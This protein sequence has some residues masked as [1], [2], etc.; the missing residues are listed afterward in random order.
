MKYDVD[1]ELYD[2]RNKTQELTKHIETLTSIIKILIDNQ[3][4]TPHGLQ[5]ELF[6]RLLT[7]LPEKE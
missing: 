7:T 2:L 5:Q 3:E 4:L 6:Q 1:K